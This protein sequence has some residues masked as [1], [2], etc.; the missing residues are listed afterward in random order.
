MKKPIV[1]IVLGGNFKKYILK[2]NKKG[3]GSGKGTQCGLLA[4][5]F[6][7]FHLSAGELLRKEV[8]HFIKISQFKG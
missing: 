2:N 7:F 6:N 8:R 1:F 3:P 5:T 4:K